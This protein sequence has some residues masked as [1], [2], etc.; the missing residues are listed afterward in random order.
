VCY[1]VPAK[2]L[3]MGVPLSTLLYSH[4]AL[5]DEATLQIPIVIFQIF[6]VLF[7]SL[8][9][10]PFRKWA[11]EGGKERHERTSGLEDEHKD[12]EAVETTSQRTASLNGIETERKEALA[13]LGEIHS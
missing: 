9:T 13:G 5:I 4:L 12:E 10:I 2:T 11:E 6:Q 7:S 8:L 3:D 1:C